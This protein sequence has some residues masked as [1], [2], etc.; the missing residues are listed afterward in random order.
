AV[1]PPQDVPPVRAV[2]GTGARDASRDG[3]E[4]VPGITPGEL[5]ADL[6]LGGAAAPPLAR[7]AVLSRLAVSFAGARVCGAQTPAAGG[8]PKRVRRRNRHV[9]VVVAGDHLPDLRAVDDDAQDLGL[10]PPQLVHD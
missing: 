1:V 8:R 6:G 3:A 7:P 2:G 5:T 4:V 10:R 9:V